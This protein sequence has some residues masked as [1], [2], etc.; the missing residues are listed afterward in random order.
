MVDYRNRTTKAGCKC[1]ESNIFA[2]EKET[3]LSG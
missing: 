3:V 1:G 2:T